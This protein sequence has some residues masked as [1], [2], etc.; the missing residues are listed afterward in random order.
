MG[1][2]SRFVTTA[3]QPDRLKQGKG[4]TWEGG[5]RT[6]AI[7]WWPGTVRPGVVTGMGSGLDLLATAA[8]ACRCTGASRS[9]DR[10]HRLDAPRSKAPGR[11]LA[12]SCSTTGTAS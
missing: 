8:V 6:P 4:T 1:P 7:F 10:L 3:V 12:T 2:G 5:V 11:V 9:T